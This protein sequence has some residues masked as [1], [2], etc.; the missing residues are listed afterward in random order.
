MTVGI[1]AVN[2]VV[3]LW[4]FTGTS[5]DHDVLHYG[6]YPT[7]A[8]VL[9]RLATDEIS[10]RQFVEEAVSAAPAPRPQRGRVIAVDI[11]A[12]VS[13]FAHRPAL[14]YLPPAWFE[15][16]RPTLP[17]ILMLPGTPGLTADWTR[18]G[19]ADQTADAYADAHRGQAPIL[20][21]A[22]PNGSDT[23]DTE[24]VDSPLGRAETYLTVDVR[25]WVTNT[26]QI[27]PDPDR[28]AVAGLSEG[29]TCAIELALRHPDLFHTFADFSGDL[30]PT[31]GTPASTISELFGGS[32]SVWQEH[33]PLTILS[34][35]RF[36][37]LSGWFEAGT[38][39]PESLAAARRLEAA[40]R[41]AGA[42]TQLVVRDGIHNFTFWAA[43]FQD[44]LP[45]LATRLGLPGP[46]G[47]GS[48]EALRL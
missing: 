19:A 45:W 14:V 26:Y 31:L 7:L 32:R 41:A 9:G 1:I 39:D 38:G 2:V 46:G 35:R 47:P 44:A 8:T 36:P 3:W 17:V 42:D 21:F 15:P 22:D 40:A 34:R 37:Q 24:C 23:G 33:D 18:A 28:W 25:R 13:G 29:G 20:V 5:V 48:S 4:E 6:Y 27:S 43:A 11:P 12:T 16:R 30:G 10:R